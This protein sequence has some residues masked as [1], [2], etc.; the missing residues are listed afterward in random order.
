MYPEK[1]MLAIMITEAL[2]PKF[3]SGNW[4]DITSQYATT[5]LPMP[6]TSQNYENL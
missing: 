1:P 5:V 3:S 6:I 4:Q 2:I